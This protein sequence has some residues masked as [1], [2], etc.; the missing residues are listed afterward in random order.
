MLPT[1]TPDG[2]QAQAPSQEDRF[3]IQAQGS[4]AD[5]RTHVLKANDTFAI[6]DRYGDFNPYRPELGLYH[7]G[8]RFLN[9]LMIRLGE[10][11][12]MIL[13]S[14]VRDDNASMVVELTNA[15]YYKNDKLILPR[16]VIYMV[17]ES[18]LNQGVLYQEFKIEN[19]SSISIQ[20]PLY[21]EF[22][23][24]Y[25]DIF[26]VRG[27]HREARGSLSEPVVSDHS[28]SIAY[29]GLDKIQRGVQLSFDPRPS[30]LGP[31]QALFYL[32]IR[33]R[34]HQSLTL[35]ATTEQAEQTPPGRY[36]FS[37]ARKHNDEQLRQGR[38]LICCIT[39]S[40][41]QF[42]QWLD[43]SQADLAMMLTQTEQGWF[44]YAGVPWY[45]TAFGRDGIISALQCL[46][47]APEISKG[48]LAFLAH[49]QATEEIP[50]QDAEPGKIIHE[51][52]YGEMAN[53]GEV[54]FGRYY[55]SV[56][57]TPL[58]VIL[59]SEYLA[60]TGDR[61]FI[62]TIWP[63]VEAT[64]KWIETYG[65]IDQ[66]GFVEY[67]RR[68]SDGLIQQGWK[69][70]HDSV[71]HSDGEMAEAP[72][73]L[74]EVQG[75][76]FCAWLGAAAMLHEFGRQAE[77][78]AYEDKAWQ[79]RERFE[80]TFWNDDLQSYVLALDGKKRPCVV[81]SSNAGQVLFSGIASPE[82]AA[83][84]AKTLMA[85]DMF[86]GWGI[87]TLS[88]HEKNYNPMSYH[89]GSIWP[90]DNA[91]IGM[92]LARYRQKE[93]LLQVLTGMFRASMVMNNQRLPELFCGFERQPGKGPTLY[94][95][96]CLPQT[97]ASVT[98]FSLLQAAL[99]LSFDLNGKDSP[100]LRFL[101]PLLPDYLQWVEVKGLKT[102]D[103]RIDLRFVYHSATDVGIEIM[104]PNQQRPFEIF[105]QK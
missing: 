25:R 38:D 102:G 11:R 69:D 26:E 59:A 71:F 44:P 4:L 9:R 24:D 22:D 6:F 100:V 68:T 42:N 49:T 81:K 57:S 19:F 93:A 55:G 96:A 65:D 64:L 98:P 37:V 104:H 67:A 47:L 54:P 72:I 80:A 39:T 23:A 29:E 83:M 13:S 94:P 16:D 61:D 41:E 8:T 79:L 105:I 27:M 35:T 89:N 78:E 30:K 82:R 73:A 40:N 14:A 86:S 53:T 62:K 70:S 17:R 77:A 101:S 46:W 36:S 99:G 20:L 2:Q 50:A 21:V 60:R 76:V 33:P 84:Q 56:D 88:A 32:N 52:R 66:D 31:N 34:S 28:V 58:F 43:R 92:G 91:L 15:D 48:T 18:F 97:W 12:P 10:L 3:Y 5:R 75:Y 74:A 90:H 87:R 95:V 85:E 51:M 7:H 45:S 1:T 63:N 103:E